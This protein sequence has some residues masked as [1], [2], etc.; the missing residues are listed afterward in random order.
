MTSK[1]SLDVAMWN[2]HVGMSCHFFRHDLLWFRLIDNMGR[3]DFLLFMT[4]TIEP[5]QLVK[6][7]LFLLFRLAI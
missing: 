5:L 2:M 7:V 3:Y 6:Y 1:Q 4:N